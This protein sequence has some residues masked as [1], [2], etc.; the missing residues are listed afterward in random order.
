MTVNLFQKHP[1]LKY[2]SLLALLILLL[3]PAP[4]AGAAKPAPPAPPAAP[5]PPAPP[6]GSIEDLLPPHGWLGVVLS[7]EEGEGVVVIGVKKESPAEKAGLM[8]GDRIL[9][10]DGT[11]IVRSRD[12]RRAMSD[13]EPGDTVQ[14]QVRRKTQEKTLTAT[15]GKPPARPLPGMGPMWH[16]RGAPGP[17]SLDMLGMARNYL[18]VR[19]Q[20][21]TE[22]LR[23]YFK[24]PRG[25][26]LLV[27][28]VEEETPAA[29]AGLR[30]GD[31]IIA[32]GGKGISER[33]D[34]AEAL[35]DYEPGDKVAVKIVR[36]GAEKTVQVEIAER[37]PPRRH[38]A[39][40]L[41]G[42]EML[43]IDRDID[44]DEEIDL[45]R[46][47][48]MPEEAEE[49]VHESVD[50]TLE[51]VREEIHRVMSELPEKKAQMAAVLRQ[52]RL[53]DLEMKEIRARMKEAMEQ[54]REAI[55]HVTEAVM[56]EPI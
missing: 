32:V 47:E 36:D 9:E 16:E 41:P 14:I 56:E 7:D 46:F 2:I 38:G 42:G 4:A 18:G 53:G 40:F 11:K 17:V 21:M 10:L 48:V 45:E 29:K 44:L 39:V 12:L 28:R 6:D 55:R 22:D 15:L 37:H 31:V 3:P 20:S 24:A 33:S 23:A 25:R 54:A 35:S 13:L 1:W 52:S 27:S 19:V 5:A 26:G 8:E 34:I 50:E 51:R 30:A 43:D 49:A